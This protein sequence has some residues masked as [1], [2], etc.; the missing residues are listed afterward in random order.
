MDILDKNNY[1][2]IINAGGDNWWLIRI[3]EPDANNP[4]FL[5]KEFRSL[6]NSSK[7]SFGFS[8]RQFSQRYIRGGFHVSFMSGNTGVML[9]FC[10]VKRDLDKTYLRHFAMRYYS[11]SKKLPR[12][13]IYQIKHEA[14][15]EII[16]QM[17]EI[18]NMELE[19]VFNSGNIPK[20]RLIRF[21]CYFGN[22]K[23]E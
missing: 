7:S 2:K 3:E 11:S 4:R 15:T 10:N 20:P 17:N 16:Q 22:N 5:V 1:E 12:L 13:S 18:I 14:N 19:N 23:N 8:N 9:I 21:G 6:F